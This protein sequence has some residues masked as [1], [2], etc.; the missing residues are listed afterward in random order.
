MSQQLTYKSRVQRIIEGESKAT[1]LSQDEVA[2]LFAKGIDGKHAAHLRSHNGILQHYRTIEGV[3]TVD[4]VIIENT[5]CWSAGFARCSIT[6][7]DYRL[8]LS[9]ISGLLGGW[10][11]AELTKIKIIDEE[12][13]DVLFLLD[14]RYFLFGHDD[15]PYLVE[16]PKACAKV[17]EAFES[18]R[19]T[20]T[21]ERTS[22]QGDLFF[23]PVKG[24]PEGLHE[25][26]HYKQL[27]RFNQYGDFDGAFG[28]NPARM[29]WMP[30]PELEAQRRKAGENIYVGIIDE[31]YR[32]IKRPQIMGT[33]HMAQEMITTDDGL[34]LVR[35]NITHPQHTKLT[36]KGWHFVRMNEAKQS[37][38]VTRR[39]GGGY[40]D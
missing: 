6:S 11:G 13:Y 19:P 1:V 37:L 23:I 20:Y 2:E 40:A 9:T 17:T 39:G 18:L 3:R 25:K 10:N 26:T 38:Q 24:E 31:T 29:P 5:Q 30:N 32:E 12:E 36:L 35:G 8:P 34:T 22:R 28:E 14:G 27:V 4:G 21:D 7:A 15:G 16:L 33:R